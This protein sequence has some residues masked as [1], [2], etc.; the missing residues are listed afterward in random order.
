M[1]NNALEMA[2]IRR[3]FIVCG[4]SEAKKIPSQGGERHQHQGKSFTDDDTGVY[5]FKFDLCQ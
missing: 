1:G 5:I 3:F 2:V 4:M